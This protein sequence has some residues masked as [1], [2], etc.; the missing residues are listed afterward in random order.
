MGRKKIPVAVLNDAGKRKLSFRRRQVSLYKKALE[1]SIICNCDLALFV[2]SE[3]NFL[4]MY[5][6]QPVEEMFQRVLEYEGQYFHVERNLNLDPNEKDSQT[7]ISVR[8]KAKAAVYED[9]LFVN[10]LDV[11][12]AKT[13]REHPLNVRAPISHTFDNL[14]AQLEGVIDVSSRKR[15]KKVESESEEDYSGM[16]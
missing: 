4:T 11:C 12:V 9:N 3:E 16:E 7:L 6:S 14:E 13:G 5:T 1:L 8:S 10:G 15:K 2:W